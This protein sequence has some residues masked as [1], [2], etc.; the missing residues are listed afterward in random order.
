[1]R[2]GWHSPFNI[3]FSSRFL[4]LLSR[5]YCFGGSLLRTVSGSIQLS[6]VTGSKTHP[7]SKTNPKVTCLRAFPCTWL[8]LQ[9]LASSSDWFVLFT[10]VLLEWPV[11]F[12]NNQTK[13]PLCKLNCHYK[14]TGNLSS[15]DGN[16]NKNVMWKYNFSFVLLRHNFNPFYVHRNCELSLPRN[17]IGR[18]GVHVLHKTLN[19]VISRCC[20]AED[21]NEM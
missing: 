2:L 4:L 21:G 5:C 18:S 20:F 8:N 12:S 17:K 3:T 10:F 13:T 19:L 11:W 1:M 7:L 14:Q 9:V 15:H 6:T 16:A